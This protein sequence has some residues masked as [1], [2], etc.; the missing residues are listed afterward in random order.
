ML[1]FLLRIVLNMME[2]VFTYLSFDDPQADLDCGQ[3]HILRHSP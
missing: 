1:A 3:L 2:M